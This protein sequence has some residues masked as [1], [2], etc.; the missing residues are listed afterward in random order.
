VCSLVRLELA[1]KI[2]QTAVIKET[3]RVAVPAPAGLPRVVPPSGAVLSDVEIPG[4]VRVSCPSVVV[5]CL[6][7]SA[8]SCEPKPP[9]RVVFGRGV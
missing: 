5:W 1:L 9:L 8:D 7:P 6:I 3:L 4:G 2:E